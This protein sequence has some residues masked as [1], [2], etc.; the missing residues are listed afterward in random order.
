VALE[1]NG[2]VYV[3]GNNLNNELGLGETWAQEYADIIRE[4]FQRVP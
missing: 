2:T 1:G 4:Q 3:W